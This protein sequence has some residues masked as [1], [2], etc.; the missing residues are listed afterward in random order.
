TSQVSLRGPGHWLFK[1]SM[2]G[3]GILAWLG[4]HWIDLLSFLMD[5]RIVAVSAM[6]ATRCGEAIDVE[7]TASIIMR[8][9]NG[10]IG[11]LRAGYA[12]K[13]FHGYDPSDLTIT[14]E[15][16][17]GAISWVP[18]R[19]EG[20][21]LRTGHPRFSGISRRTVQVSYDVPKGAMGYAPELMEAF[22]DAI[23]HGREPPATAQHAL[24]VLRVL[25]A[26]YRSADEHR[27]VEVAP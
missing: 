23:E 13:P 16:S 17:L 25:E 14:M 22:L 21:R 9:D 3:G 19:R 10:C 18:E 12:L 4:C 2:S 5:S 7:D 15:G 27:E 20:Y 11:A 26:A 24:H 6:I 1:R 8:F